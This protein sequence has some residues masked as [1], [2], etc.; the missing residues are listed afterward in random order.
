MDTL[1]LD[2]NIAYVLLV[3]GLLMAVLALV[4]PGT[5][6]LEIGALLVLALAGWG[7]YRL[8]VNLVALGVLGLGV[9]LFGLALWAT[10]QRRIERRRASWLLAAAILALV[11]GSAFLFRLEPGWAPAVNPLLALV[12]ASLSSAYLWIAARKVIESEQRQPTHD[13]DRLIGMRGEAKSA[14]LTSG[15]ALVDGEL[16]SVHSAT[17]I[18]AGAEVQVLR[19][20]GLW[21]EVAPTAAPAADLTV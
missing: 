5:G 16:W 8:P 18:P 15:T 10:V 12:V 11:G 7:I 21:L 1:L 9:I 17:P 3:S 19:R 13:L 20:S 4:T 6:V 14:I 2:P